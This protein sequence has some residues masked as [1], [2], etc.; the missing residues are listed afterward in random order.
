MPRL[1]LRGTKEV[2]CRSRLAASTFVELVVTIFLLTVFAALAFPVFWGASK[3]NTSHSI[4]AAAQRARLSL[5]TILPR[6]C[7][8]VRPP[9]WTNPDKVFQ[10]S[11]TEWKVYYRNGKDSDFLILR[12]ESESRLS[13][14]TSD[15]N[16]SIDNLNG[17][18]VDWWKQD[19][20][21]IGFRIQWLQDNQTME[22]HAAW[23]SFIL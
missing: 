17:L 8:E 22:F 7:E 14:A 1:I 2:K 13:L 3:A 10:S 5:S 16:V 18:A 12:K 9:Y 21:I 11:G 15:S 6:L 23:G 4:T 19:K 20:R